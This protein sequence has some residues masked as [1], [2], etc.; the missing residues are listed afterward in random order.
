MGLLKRITQKFTSR[1]DLDI[2]KYFR[3]KLK[4]IGD[5]DRLHSLVKIYIHL[6]TDCGCSFYCN[7]IFNSF[8]F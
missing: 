6:T 7:R 3:R 4:K 5:I 2:F 8:L 1:Q